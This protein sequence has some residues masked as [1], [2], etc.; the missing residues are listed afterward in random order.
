MESSLR[1]PPT[2]PHIRIPLLING[3]KA[4]GVVDNG[5]SHSMLTKA[6]AN[7]TKT[8]YHRVSRPNE[9][10]QLEAGSAGGSDLVAPLVELEVT[11]GLRTSLNIMV[12]TPSLQVD[13]VLGLDVLEELGMRPV[14]LPAS[15]PVPRHA[16]RSS[17]G[18]GNLPPGADPDEF[19]IEH[20]RLQAA[21]LSDFAKA[22]ASRIRQGIQAALEI[23]EA[24]PPDTKCSIP[25]S[26]VYL[27]TGDAK[28]VSVAPYKIAKSF[29]DEIDKIIEK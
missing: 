2:R 5:S 14:H 16:R 26:T 19:W 20:F 28:P 4:W 10:H 7:H 9:F 11:G 17:G 27:D 15:F 13:I 18:R 22:A 21:E 12:G 6:W 3:R 1:L 29:E 25:D 23:N 8:V 24:L